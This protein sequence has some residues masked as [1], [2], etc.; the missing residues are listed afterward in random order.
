MEPPT[1]DLEPP[2]PSREIFWPSG[3][4]MPILEGHRMPGRCIL[5][6]FQINSNNPPTDLNISTTLTVQENQPIGT[7]VGSFTATDPD[8]NTT[9]S[10]SLVAGVGD[11]NN[12]LF[13]L[14]SNGSLKTAAL[15]DHE[16][17]SLSIRVQV[18]DENNASIDGNFTV[19]VTNE[20][21]APDYYQWYGHYPESAGGWKFNRFHISGHRSGQ[22]GCAYPGHLFLVDGMMD[23][24]KWYWGFIS[25][26][27]SDHGRGTK[28]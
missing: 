3:P 9:F 28:L 16:A 24:P 23:H 4:I 10:Y 17:G 11:G 12:S 22:R 2:F 7:T 6:I 20:N 18:S 26:F 19:L 21:E 27:C 13:T 15:L 25:H 1:I 14:E 5:L 8:A